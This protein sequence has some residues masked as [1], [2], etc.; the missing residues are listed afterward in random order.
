MV[1]GVGF[2][3]EGRGLIARGNISNVK[4]TYLPL[5]G[6]CCAMLCRRQENYI[7]PFRHFTIFWLLVSG[8]GFRFSG[9]GTLVTRALQVDLDTDS[10]VGIPGV[11][12]KPICLRIPVHNLDFVY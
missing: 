4:K 9:I 5:Q 11:R 3:V 6:L 10:Q 1:K 8:F 2:R 7:S 12:F